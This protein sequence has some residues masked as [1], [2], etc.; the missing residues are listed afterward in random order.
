MIINPVVQHLLTGIG[1]SLALV[2]FS[3]ATNYRQLSPHLPI[4]GRRLALFASCV[5]T[6]AILCEATVN[7]FYEDHFGSKL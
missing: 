1:F 4:D 3:Y 6:L 2:T 7:P 5:F